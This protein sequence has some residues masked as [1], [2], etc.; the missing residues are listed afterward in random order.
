VSV[1]QSASPVGGRVAAA[2][3]V[4]PQVLARI[5]NLE[6][7]SRMV[8]D[9]FISGLHQAVFQGASVDFAEHRPYVPGD[10]IRRID[11]KL[12]ARSDRLY[13]KTYVAET[14]ANVMFALDVSRSMDYASRGLSKLDYGRFVVGC[15]AHLAGRQRDHVGLTGL[16]TDLVEMQPPSARRREALMRQLNRLQARG[17]GD[18]CAALS[19]LALRLRRR[20]IVVVVSDF[21]A[22][23]RALA[24]ALDELRLRGQE[25]IAL[26]L[27]DPAERD[28]DH[29]GPVVLEDMESGARVPVVPARIKTEYQRQVRSHIADLEQVLGGRR[30]DYACFHT[31][32]PLDY[33]LHYYLSMRAWRIRSRR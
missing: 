4:D 32:Q 24:A 5:G 20:G 21:Y 30:I 19:R 33:M 2:R 1:A 26:H 15:L 11:W 9:G 13:L 14:N 29:A 7:V 8:V 23:P 12:F 27:L 17:P 6:L 3:F 31:D 16:D 18:I 28:L 25:V 10:D 22:E